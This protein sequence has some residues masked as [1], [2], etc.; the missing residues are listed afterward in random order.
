[1]GG[2]NISFAR[3][4]GGIP[5]L[6]ERIPGSESAG[7]M[8]GVSTGSRD[9]DKDVMGISHLLEH[10]VFRETKNRSSY[11]MAKE[12]EGAGGELNAFTGREMT[13]FFGVTIKE[14]KDVAKDTVSDIVANP[15]IND[16]D[17]ELEKKIVL[18]ELSM[19]ENEPE[20]YIHDLF[21]MNLWRGHPLSQDEG[22]LPEIV[23]R[24]GAKELRNY[25]EE[26][27]GI[28]NISVFAAGAVEMEEVLSWAEEKFDILSGK[29]EI[30]RER[31]KTP[32]AGYSFTRNNSEHY[33]VAMGFP[34]YDPG[35]PD[36]VP[37]MLLS[38]VIGSGT[39]S[40]LF[41]EV[42]EKKALVYSVHN[43]VEQHSDA[44]AMCTYLSSTD[45]NMI[46]AVETVAKV[47]RNI[48]DSGLEKGELE[49]TKN[50]IKGVLVRSMEST[51]RRMYRLGREFLLSGKYQSLGDRLREISNVTEEDL[52]RVA[53]DIIKASS[54]NASVLGRKNKEIEKFNSSQ[55]DL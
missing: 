8:V 46:E 9:E 17:V 16:D 28:P 1:M 12:M 5:V 41:Q 48:R 7:Y 54:L 21:S 44:A 14:T 36:R 29:K 15:L 3:T 30:K 19:I 47:Y 52:M 22:G 4:S 2:E 31:P 13:A 18:Q 37:L 50:L 43:V 38:A 27:Y 34:A 20:E 45:E 35:H 49:R 11:Q 23:K 39:S 53:S 26:R 40:R 6:I 55:L 42:R 24:L 10:V 33:H 32:E 25:Y 51:E